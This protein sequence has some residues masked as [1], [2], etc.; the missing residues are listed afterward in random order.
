MTGTTAGEK[1]HARRFTLGNRSFELV[2]CLDARW[3]S[4]GHLDLMG[5]NA[6]PIAADYFFELGGF[7]ARLFQCLVDG[8]FD[9]SDERV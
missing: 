1:G 6:D 5:Q 8:G 2:C 9:F 4:N 3:G 7:E